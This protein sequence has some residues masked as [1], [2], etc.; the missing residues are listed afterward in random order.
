M[1]KISIKRWVKRSPAVALGTALILIFITGLL[2]FRLTTLHPAANA[3]EIDALQR[4]QSLSSLVNNPINFVY[5]LT[6][7]V[8]SLL[9]SDLT[10]LRLTSVIFSL[11]TLLSVRNTLKYWYDLRTANL[12]ALLLASSFWFIIA[13]RIGSP[14]IMP[15]FW[16]AALLS[17]VSWQRYTPKQKTVSLLIGATVALGIYSPYF[18][19]WLL[20]L[21]IVLVIHYGLKNTLTKLRLPQIIPIFLIILPLLIAFRNFD[22]LKE[23]LGITS[24]T[25]APLGY[26]SNIVENFS[27]IIIR[28]SLDPALNLGRLPYL[29]I[30]QVLMLLLGI[31]IFFTHRKSFRAMVTLYAPLIYIGLI[32]ILTNSLSAL[33]ILLPLIFIII[34]VGFSELISM[35]LR[36]FPRNPVGRIAGL[37]LCVILISTSGYYN[38]HRYYVAWAD[39]P[40]VKATHNQRQ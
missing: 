13:G 25:R 38:L 30:F 32:S 26:L 11:L 23:L 7:W 24:L 31:T 15:A 19:W 20:A 28:G 34:C 18:I 1:P 29:D 4:L 33:I 14:L 21:V 12:G 22:I 6:A 8:I 2:I 16:S 5:Y 3:Y 17:L 10:A 27:Q 35:W 40:D 36:G 37:V 39:N 9:V